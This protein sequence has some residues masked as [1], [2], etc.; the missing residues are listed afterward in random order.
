MR[1]IKITLLLSFL[2]FVIPSQ[3]L[4]NGHEESKS[5]KKNVE[6]VFELDYNEE[7]EKLKIS[8]FGDF[9]ELSTLSITNTRGSEILFSFI[10]KEQSE[11]EFSV[12]KLE[13]GSYFVILNTGDEIRMKRFTKS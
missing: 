11:I 9:E 4:A 7:T 8:V 13:P 3:L 10:Q 2:L 12:D 1:A 6:S 5:E